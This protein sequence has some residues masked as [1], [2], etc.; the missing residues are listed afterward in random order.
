MTK[1]NLNLE[2][3]LNQ[4]LTDGDMIFV[5]SITGLNQSTVAL[6]G[7]FKYP[8]KYSVKNGEKLSS[9]L[10]RADGFSDNAFLYGTVL[11][12]RSV[13]EMQNASF[14]RAA[15]DMET[16]IAGAI[17]G[18]QVQGGAVAAVSDLLN[19]LRTTQSPG[20]L[21]VDIDP[22]HL[23]S[24]PAKD[25]YLEDGDT[26]TIPSRINA[27]TVVGDVYS[28]GTIP[29]ENLSKLEDY[30]AKAGGLRPSADKGEI[31]MILPNGEARAIQS[32]IWRLKKQFISPG[33]TIYIPRD[34]KPFD[35][36][37]ATQ[38]FTPILSNLATTAAAL[39]AIN[40]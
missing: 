23:A 17:I 34:T 35:W 10:K 18:G 5:P 14:R 37:I 27:V 22:I 30:I 19:R 8:G 2:E 25:I 11:T 33:S 36:L 31:F 32:G 28:P 1:I 4:K 16:A 39:A 20:R 15:D 13:S 7:Q 9:L 21:I 6:S 40:N 3:N 12:R 24:N 26:I 29:F 38:T